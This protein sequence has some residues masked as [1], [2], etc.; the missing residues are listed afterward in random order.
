MSCC[1]ARSRCWRRSAGRRRTDSSRPSC[2][3]PTPAPC[4]WRPASGCRRGA[5]ALRRHQRR[6]L[7]LRARPGP[8][9]TPA[10]LRRDSR[11]AAPALRPPGHGDPPDPAAGRART[12]VGGAAR[13]GRVG[14]A[15]RE[16]GAVLPGPGR[17]ASRGR[18][19]P[20]TQ[21]ARARSARNAVSP[22]AKDGGRRPSRRRRGARFQQHPHGDHQLRGSRPAQVAGA[23]PAA[24]QFR[25]DHRRLRPRR[26][27]DAATPRVFAPPGAGRRASSTSTPSSPNWARRCAGCSARTSELSISDRAGACAHHGRPGADRTIDHQSDGERPGRHAAG[28]GDRHCHHQRRT[29]RFLHPQPSRGRPRGVRVP[30]GQRP[31]PRHGRELPGGARRTGQRA[32]GAVQPASP[33]GRQ[34]STTSSSRAAGMLRIETSPDSGTTVRIC[35]PAVKRRCRRIVCPGQHL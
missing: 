11:G 10:L 6:L 33:W 29:R 31:R 19:A 34:P 23:E 13:A 2:R 20:P 25:G 18:T 15:P 7:P 16:A 14:L 26:A 21:R 17:N 5:A 9:G 8:A 3:P 28:W 27:A 30:R 22:G 1:S 35:F 12:R 24:P 4:A 32:A